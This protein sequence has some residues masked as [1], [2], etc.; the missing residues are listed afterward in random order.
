[1][2]F[3]SHNH[4]LETVSNINRKNF[5][6]HFTIIIFQTLI[7]CSVF[8][9]TT[10]RYVSNEKWIPIIVRGLLHGDRTENTDDGPQCSEVSKMC[11]SGDCTITLL[12]V[13]S[14][15]L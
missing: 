15:F 9:E 12:R 6:S 5:N 2:V 4:F 1:M 8:L 14:T 11:A 13:K 7:L 10:S 3:S